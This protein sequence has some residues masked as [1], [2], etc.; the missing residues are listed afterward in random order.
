MANL[1]ALTTLDLGGNR[2]A[3]LPES[4]RE[5]D[6][7]TRLGLAGNQLTACRNRWGT[8]SPS[9]GWTCPVTS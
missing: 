2:L 8:W 1:A 4:V 9:P 6:A 3:A 7:L 5:P